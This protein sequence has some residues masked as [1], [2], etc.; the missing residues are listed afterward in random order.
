MKIIDLTMPL[1]DGMKVYPGDPKV[2]IKQVHDLKQHG[3]RLR[4]LSMGSH[5]GT[6]VDAFSHMDEK[7]LT[8]DKIP[9]ERFVGKAVKVT[10]S[11]LFP[12]GKGLIFEEL[13]TEDDFQKI[14]AHQPNFV[15]GNIDVNLERLLLQHQVITY[16]NLIHLDLLP[17]NK[18]FIF[19]GLPLNIKNGDGSPVRA[20]AIVDED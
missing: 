7:G 2:E 8:L 17:G 12:K 6:H 11:D 3:W 10:S 18:E 15:A 13:V 4:A 19:I 9:L 5:T 16:T 14:M 20:V 1:N